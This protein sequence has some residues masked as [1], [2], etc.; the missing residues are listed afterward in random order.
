MKGKLVV[1]CLLLFILCSISTVC[2]ED[3]NDTQIIQESDA[4]DNLEVSNDAVL[5]DSSGDLQKIISAASA[6]STVK[7]NS[8]YTPASTVNIDKSLTIDGA[9]NTIKG[10]IKSSSGTIT[11]KNMKFVDGNSHDGSAI[12]I[13]GSAKFTIINCTFTNNKA[14]HYGGAIYNNVRNTL[15]VQDCK[16]TGNSAKVSGGA[17][18]SKG[19]IVVEKSVFEKNTVV[20]DGGAIKCEETVTISKSVFNSNS[21][22]FTHIAYGGA[23]NVKQDGFIDNCAFNGNSANKGG[24]IFGYNDLIIENSQ[25]TENRAKYEGGAIKVSSDSHLY[26]ENSTFKKNTATDDSGGAIYSN[27]WT[28][29]GNSVFE[30]NT[31]KGKG[32]AIK[33]EYI[34]FSG[35]NTFTSNSAKD[36]G[37]AVYTNTIGNENKNLIFDGNHADSDFGGAIYIN[38]KSGDVRF[39]SSVFKN[40]HANAGDGGAIHS[41]S[42]STDLFFTNCTFTSNYATGGKERRY[43]GAVRSKGGINVNNCTFKD[44]WAENYGGAIYT[45]KLSEI[46]NSVF[47]SNQVKNGGTRNGGA[48]YVN[49]AC[50]MTISGNYFEKNG[51]QASRG[52]V[53]YTDSI[54]AHVK[55]TNNAFIENAASDQGVSVFNSGYY[56]DISNNW[57]GIN[58][59]SIGN[60]LKEYHRIKSNSNKFD[61]K[62]LTVSIAADKNVYSGVKT[63]IKVSFTG[64]VTYY[65]LDTLKYSSNKKGEFIT[66]KIN[67][68]NLELIYVPNEAGTHKIDFT[69]N[70]Q[71]LSF[72]MNVKYT[73]VYGYDIKKTYG[74]ESLYSAVFKDKN[75]NYLAKG[76][77]VTFNVNNA[78][79]TS[80][81]T[82]NGA[83]ILYATFEPGTYTVK[84]NNP[85][86]GESY[87]NKI[88]VEKRNMTYNINDPYIVKVNASANQTVTFKIGS[89]TFTDKTSEDGLA[90]FILNVTAGS[91][92]VET[93]FAGKTIKDYITVANN[94][95]V[96]DLGLNGT[97]YGAL[98]PIY[99]NETFKMI[100]NGTMYS[101][102]GKDTYRYVMANGEAFIMYNVTVSNSQEL[103]EVL[104]KMVRT[105][106]KVDV[107]IIN[108]K[109][110]TYKVTEKFWRDAEWDYLSHLT[111]GTLIIRGNGST[112]ED[113]YKHNFIGM[114]P[115]SSLMVENLEFKKFYRVFASSGEVYCENCTFTENNA[116]FWATS[117]QG[118][119]IYNKNK[120]TFINCIFN[121]NDNSGGGSG[122]LGGVLYADRNSLTNFVK[123]S[124]KTDDDNIRAKEKSMVVIYDDYNQ[125][126]TYNH[127]VKNSYFDDNSSM[128]L[129][130]VYSF[131]HNTTKDFY[132]SN[133][134]DLNEFNKWVDGS[135]DATL[136]N[137]TLK[138][139]EYI[140]SADAIKKNR[141]NNEWRGA[142]RDKSILF[143]PVWD[144][145]YL[146][147]NSKPVII[148]GNGA[149]IRLTGN[150]VSDDYHFAYIPNYGSLTLINLT[151]SGFNTAILNFGTFTAINCTFKDNVIHHSVVIYDYGGAIRNFGNVY[152]YN[153]LFKDNG[154]NKGGAYYSIGKGANGV[155]YNCEFSGNMIKSNWIWKNNDKNDFEIDQLSVVKL[156]NSRGYS[157]STIKTEEGGLYLERESLNASVYNA[158]VDNMA[159]LMRVTKIINGNTK[160]DLINITMLKDDYG[161]LP[162]QKSLFKADYG[163]VI[164]NGGGA[165]I[166]VQN[167]HD[168][169]TTQFLT[170]A[171][172]GNVHL[173]NL[174]IEGFNIAIENSGTLT[175]MNCIFKNNKVDYNF[176][177]DYG[178]A[179][180]NKGILN[181]FNSTFTNNY[182]KYGGAIFNKGSAKVIM[183]IFSENTGYSSV[184]KLGKKI[185][186]YNDDGSLEDV[187]IFGGDHRNYENHP[188]A[189][190]RKDLIQSS[191]I[192]LTA[193]VTA[194]A[195]WGIAATGAAL[196]PLIS[197]G[198]NAIIGGVL[199]GIY[200]A[201]YANDHHDYSTFWRDVL[202]GVGYGLQ[203][204]PFGG[205][206]KG[207]PQGHAM[208]VGIVQLF[209]KTAAQL[210]KKA[211]AYANQKQRESKITYFT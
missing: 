125:W 170:V 200:G 73:S 110:N 177:A 175:I 37:G 114:E 196:A 11:L 150:G 69:I 49:K 44:N 210:D 209:G 129:R 205:A 50:T 158:A 152:C 5:M 12:Y 145:A 19:D 80:T 63:T 185:D 166:F 53:L 160:Y 10:Q 111:H 28:H 81:V 183:S 132:I 211:I 34:Q 7:L 192:L 190:W 179:I 118:S 52:G 93:T 151:L 136:F 97:S 48:I 157:P 168:D 82:D 201:I 96:I 109:K 71:K 88:T 128:S 174:I 27:K 108:L 61:S 130:T 72:D 197:M 161:V 171:S 189:S 138:K 67:S 122:K 14:N 182:A 121:K 94:Y 87:S 198:V 113:D 89:K 163:L 149:T 106:Y 123:C 207:I 54:N 70:S 36:D 25:F 126:D 56:D 38:K 74:D 133:V 15:T 193:A 206:I 98:L 156:V 78:Q 144:Q 172:R 204:S 162:N 202:K 32:G 4:I 115:G 58:K 29:I 119:V 6:G 117:T 45:E 181:I 208:K 141:E 13:T 99:S 20:H 180:V 194:G 176:K 39:Y 140:L 16:F 84:A 127:L 47:I 102:L 159:S 95:S 169:D 31:A 86:T 134:N 112:L 143:M 104:R 91:Y 83:A 139:G 59:A 131:T 137:V 75:G 79:Y 85:V 135:N 23:I 191:F 153:S 40:N 90:G 195:G 76:T 105:D 8:S 165:R 33:T 42:S 167:P 43:G 41:D 46:K 77:K 199:G 154:A 188:M 1:I 147:L 18:Y 30:L 184:A 62:P 60:Q 22:D 186:I 100:S 120:A 164:I 203:F 92:T 9:G 65:V 21:A 103:T 124:F 2:A 51:G 178:G 35:K 187:V 3:T 24:A 66:K 26:V 64:P 17:I 155:F 148:N 107:T 142:V 101:V 116:K 57:W 55:L 173:S 146:D 68:N